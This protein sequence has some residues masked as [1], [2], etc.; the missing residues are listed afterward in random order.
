MKTFSG[1]GLTDARD[2]LGRLLDAEETQSNSL[3]LW[4]EMEALRDYIQTLE[5]AENLD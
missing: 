2:Y 4:Y 3:E 5:N 1:P